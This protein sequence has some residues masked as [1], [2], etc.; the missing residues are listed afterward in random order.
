MIWEENNFNALYAVATPNF[1]KYLNQMANNETK[2]YENK[3]K[4]L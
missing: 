3:S 2:K 1:E 4:L